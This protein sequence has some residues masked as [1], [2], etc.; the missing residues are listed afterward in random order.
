MPNQID[1]KLLQ[2]MFGNALIKLVDK[3]INTTNKEE[4]QT[5]VKIIE[6]NKMKLQEQRKTS[7]YDYVIQQLI[8]VLT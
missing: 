2:K 1:E 3:L 8:N 5:I 4:N 6:N 7:P